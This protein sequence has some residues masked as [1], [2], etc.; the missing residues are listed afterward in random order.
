MLRRAECSDGHPGVPCRRRRVQRL[1]GG[2]TDRKD[3]VPLEQPYVYHRRRL[4]EPDW[5]RLPGWRDATAADW[6]S[7]QWQRAHC[8]KSVKQLREV[9]G[10]LLEDRF[11]DDLARD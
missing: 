6:S 1:P 3:A 5:T 11:Y 8:V 10:G 4:V 9:F 2:A 7:A